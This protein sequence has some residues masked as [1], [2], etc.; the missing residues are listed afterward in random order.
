M[1]DPYEINLNDDGSYMD[2]H[3]IANDII[4]N[5]RIADIHHFKDT[6]RSDLILFHNSL[7]MWIRNSYGLWQEDYSHKG[8]EHPD[9][10]SFD[11]IKMLYDNL[12]NN[13]NTTSVSTPLK[14]VT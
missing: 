11:I 8:D 14:D 4:D 7:G 10:F 13:K 3:Q 12:T 2:Q 1:S 5:D 6:K 9:D